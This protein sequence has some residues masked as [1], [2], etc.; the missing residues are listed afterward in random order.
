MIETEM[1]KAKRKHPIF[2]MCVREGFLNIYEEMGES[3]QAFNDND[4]KK[5]LIELEHVIVTCKRQMEY[6]KTLDQVRI[7]KSPV[8]KIRESIARGKYDIEEILEDTGLPVDDFYRV[9]EANPE[10]RQYVVEHI[11]FK[12]EDR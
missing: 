5:A 3:V 6:V 10:L 11:E 12:E 8:E 1:K 2:A 7:E 4:M 9:I